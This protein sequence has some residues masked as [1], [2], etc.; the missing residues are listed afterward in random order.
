ME[1]VLIS[2]I[3]EDRVGW[4][5]LESEVIEYLFIKKIFTESLPASGTVLDTGYPE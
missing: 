4:E 2:G 5:Y 3:R 1:F